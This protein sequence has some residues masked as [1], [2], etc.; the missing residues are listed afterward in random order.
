[1]YFDKMVDQIDAVAVSTPDHTHFPVA[2]ERGKT[3]EWDAENM[4][5]TGQPEFDSWIKEP[6]RKGWQFGENV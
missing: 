2:M 3:I 6:V 1:M 4:K 5:V